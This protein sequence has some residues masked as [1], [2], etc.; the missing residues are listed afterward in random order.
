MYRKVGIGGSRIFFL[1]K[2]FGSLRHSFN[3]ATT[4]YAID[5]DITNLLDR[6][7]LLSKKVQKVDYANRWLT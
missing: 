3:A 1:K 2:S 4:A 7:L 6:A 5:I